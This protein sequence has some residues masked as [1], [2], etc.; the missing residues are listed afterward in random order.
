MSIK[1]KYQ[2]IRLSSEEMSASDSET[3]TLL[4]I[5]EQQM[6]QLYPLGQDTFRI[7]HGINY[8]AFVQRLGEV[9]Y[10]VI[11]EATTTETI[12]G[13]GCA[14]LRAYNGT[15]FW[16]LCD[17]KIDPQ[18]RGQNLTLQLFIRMFLPL[19]SKS[20]KGYLISMDPSSKQ[21]IKIFDKIDSV[22]NLG[23]VPNPVL[24]IYSVTK[25]Q[26]TQLEP[27]FKIAFGQISY[28]SLIGIKDLILS[29]TQEKLNLYHVQHGPFGTDRGTSLPNLPD[30]ATVMFCLPKDSAFMEILND[31]QIQTNVSATVISHGM[32][33][34]DWH[35][36]LTS[37][38]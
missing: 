3:N 1:T 27:Y 17:L 18:H 33:F 23:I 37:D 16:Y 9:F 5:F 7:D 25:S 24:F 30:S 22:V 28:L 31:Y 36:I 8:F 10:F 6:S 11:H 19:I 15:N 14:I 26:M 4:K 2:F 34:F 21:I 35:W 13:T 32:D 38:I 29:S 20:S 12:V